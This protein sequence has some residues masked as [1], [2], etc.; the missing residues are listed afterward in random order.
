[1]IKNERTKNK[2]LN[3]IKFKKKLRFFFKVNEGVKDMGLYN[4]KK[5]Y[6]GFV[7]FVK[8]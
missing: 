4:V 1:M 2:F 5:F 8:V 3:N 7:I 6:K